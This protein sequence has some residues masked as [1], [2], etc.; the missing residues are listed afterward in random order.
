M[1]KPYGHK[2][3]AKRVRKAGYSFASKLES[4]LHDY[5]LWMEKNGQIKELK[6]QPQVY[7]TDARI[8]MKPDFSAVDTKTNLLQFYEAKGV[9]TDVW[10]V[11]KKLWTVY[12]WGPLYIYRGTYKK[13]VL[14][15]VIVPKKKLG[16]ME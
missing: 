10:L 16:G 8:V 14:S 4:S 15:E 6:L 9:N 2:Y 7:L 3:G 1:L 5:L 13:L 11:K 12:G